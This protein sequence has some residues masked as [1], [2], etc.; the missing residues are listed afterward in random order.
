MLLWLLC[1]L[2]SFYS[3]THPADL[4]QL[5]FLLHVWPPDKYKVKMYSPFSS[6]LI[7]TNS[8]EIF[9]FSYYSMKTVKLCA[10]KSKQGAK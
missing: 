8:R 5:L 10:V 2:F 6:V 7:P 9:S 4:E 1:L 3:F